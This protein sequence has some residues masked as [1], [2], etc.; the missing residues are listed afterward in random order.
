LGNSALTTRGCGK[1]FRLKEIAFTFL[2]ARIAHWPCT[3]CCWQPQTSRRRVRYSPAR[4]PPIPAAATL[5]R[6]DIL[7]VP[8]PSG[9]LSL[10]VEDPATWRD[11]SEAIRGIAVARA[12][13]TLSALWP[14]RHV[15]AEWRAMSAAAA[16]AG[17]RDGWDQVP[18]KPE[19]T[20]PLRVEWDTYPWYREAVLECAVQEGLASDPG[21][22]CSL[23]AW[24]PHARRYMGRLRLVDREAACQHGELNP[25]KGAVILV[26]VIQHGPAL[27]VKHRTRE[28][29][30]LAGRA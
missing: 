1:T 10:G 29:P 3:A 27:A 11:L 22:A 26:A 25:V 6:R 9:L 20:D 13:T 2:T 8:V 19:G 16:L 21:R 17:A 23:Q 14:G 18:V 15:I 24:R 4:L 12:T 30:V 28:S 5:E 7:E